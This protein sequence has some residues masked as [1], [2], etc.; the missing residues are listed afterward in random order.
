M[1]PRGIHRNDQVGDG[2]G[3]AQQRA[4]LVRGGSRFTSLKMIQV[5]PDAPTAAD[6]MPSLASASSVPCSASDAISSDTVK[7]IPATAPAPTTA[8]QPTGGRTRP[9]VIRVTSHAQP[10]VPAGFPTR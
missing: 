9:R 2:L 6:R 1:I 5:R 8:P 4:Q 3:R 10:L 7:P